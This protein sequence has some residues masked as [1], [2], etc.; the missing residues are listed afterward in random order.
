MISNKIMKLN[1]KTLHN[2][3]KEELDQLY[4]ADAAEVVKKLNNAITSID[5]VI[6]GFEGDTFKEVKE[7][8]ETTKTTIKSVGDKIN[9]LSQ[10]T[11]AESEELNE[12]FPL[13]SGDRDD[14]NINPKEEGFEVGPTGLTSEKKTL[15][16]GEELNFE[17]LSEEE[18]QEMILGELE[19]LYE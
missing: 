12:I 8:L 6:N 9:P 4:E 1:K 5:E 17:D 14:E 7:T 19:S 16:Q 2:L 11:M 18:L 10:P 3:I 15:I 13:P